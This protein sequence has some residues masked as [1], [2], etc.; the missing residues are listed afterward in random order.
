MGEVQARGV[1]GRI[2]E[3][4]TFV[5]RIVAPRRVSGEPEASHFVVA[6]V[7]RITMAFN[8]NTL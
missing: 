2:G 6:L 3:A 8:K 5:I 7:T 4:V 1:L